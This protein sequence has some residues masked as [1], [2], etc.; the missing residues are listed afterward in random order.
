MTTSAPNPRTARLFEHLDH[1]RALL[2]RTVEE[3]PPDLRQR[4]PAPERWSA[5]E[6]LE[7]LV[8]VERRLTFLF[9]QWLAEAREQGLPPGD[10]TDA[11]SA[12]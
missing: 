8:L 3:I 12:R 9:N 11:E 7:H 4:R 5:I 2:R 10:D 1:H 6:I